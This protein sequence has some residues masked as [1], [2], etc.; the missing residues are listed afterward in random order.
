MGKRDRRVDAYIAKSPDFAKPI[1][2]YLRDKWSMPFFEYKGALCNM[3]AFKAHCAFGFWKR[4][5]MD[6]DLGR[7]TS[8]DDLPPKKE[9]IPLLQKAAKLNEEGV[10]PAR[11]VASKGP[12]EIPGDLSAATRQPRLQQAI[13]WMSVGKSRNWKYERK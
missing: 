4:Q 6:A 9:L 11:K 5:L 10:K 13:E 2:E 12:I 8:L 3:A 7:I 1:L